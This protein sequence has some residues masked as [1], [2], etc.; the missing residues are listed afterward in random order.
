MHITALSLLRV[1][2]NVYYRICLVGVEGEI[3]LH[4]FKTYV[5]IEPY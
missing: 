5:Y 2:D 4:N 3:P 1:T